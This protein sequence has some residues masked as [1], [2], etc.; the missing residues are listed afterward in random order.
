LSIISPII[1]ILE[2]RKPD[3][4]KAA[5]TVRTYALKYLPSRSNR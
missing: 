3:R 1:A 4:E 2:K 5:D